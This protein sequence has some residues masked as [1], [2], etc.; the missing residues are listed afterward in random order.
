MGTHS[1]AV[2]KLQTPFFPTL[3]SLLPGQEATTSAHRP[4]DSQGE[5]S[6][7]LLELGLS[8]ILTS[9]GRGRGTTVWF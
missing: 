2:A 4:G 3:L 9:L 7:L 5:D 1:F 6:F 8:A